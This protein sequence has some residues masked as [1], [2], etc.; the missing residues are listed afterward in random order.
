MKNQTEV[1]GRSKPQSSSKRKVE[2]TISLSGRMGEPSEPCPGGEKNSIL[3]SLT[4]EVSWTVSEKIALNRYQESM[5]L[6]YLCCE[7]LAKE[8]IGFESYLYILFLLEKLSKGGRVR[9]IRD[10]RERHVCLI[11]YTLLR[12]FPSFEKFKEKNVKE[13]KELILSFNKPVN[14]DSRT[15]GSILKWN[16][17]NYLQAKTVPLEL[18]IERSGF[19][20]RYSSY[21]KGYGEGGSLSSRSRKTRPSA[22]LDGEPEDRPEPFDGYGQSF[23]VQLILL[24]NKIGEEPPGISIL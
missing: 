1:S 23:L 14:F 12:Y 6:K 11:A 22:E 8:F 10:I 13:L 18:L 21:C 7:V 24:L 3:N 5:I 2:D 16:P 9:E 17:R 15:F 20:K 4:V 19:S